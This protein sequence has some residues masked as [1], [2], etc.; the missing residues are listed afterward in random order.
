M[1]KLK[2]LTSK[3]AAW[4]VVLGLP[5]GGRC[6][7]MITGMYEEKSGGIDNKLR[8]FKLYIIYALGS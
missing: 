2:Q 6:D 7:N 1:A 3:T 8:L 5:S 4:H